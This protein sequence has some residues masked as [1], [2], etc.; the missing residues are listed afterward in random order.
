MGTPQ[1][2][3]LGKHCAVDVCKQIDFLPFTYDRCL[4]VLCLDH[5]SYMLNPE[6]VPNVAWEEHVNSICDHSNDEK[7]VKKKKICP[8]PSCYGPKKPSDSSL[9]SENTKVA[10]SAPASSTSSSSR[11]SSLL[12]SLE[13]RIR[14][15]RLN[16]TR[17]RGDSRLNRTRVERREI[18]QEEAAAA[19][20]KNVK[21]NNQ[22]ESFGMKSK[23]E[24]E[25]DDVE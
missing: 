13:A 22:Q 10:T 2:P 18:S 24:V 16:T 14:K 9:S 7:A 5:R 6:E 11:S 23:R 20:L 8:V 1:F 4:Q 12:A 17:V 25:D 19:N 21:L 15:K 3:D